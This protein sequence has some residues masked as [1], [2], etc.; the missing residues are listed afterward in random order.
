MRH[1]P[2]LALLRRIATCRKGATLVEFA[3]I[4]PVLLMLIMG[5]FD[6]GHNIYTK[7]LLEG[8]VQKAARDSTIESASARADAIDAAVIEAVREVAPTAELSFKRKA[9]TNFSDVARPED[10]TDVDKNGKCSD[11]EPFEDVNG[12]G[13]WDS[14][15]GADGL[16]G[17]R[18]AVLYTVRIESP[19]LFPIANMIGLPTTFTTEAVT[20]LRNQ[21]FGEQEIPEPTVGNCP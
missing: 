13:E 3:M 5:L 9:Y 16:G 11:G 10:F 19:R 2:P 15:R 14:D 6:M 20:V 17:A 21:P 1:P 18:D 4:A 8:A 7:T 12:N